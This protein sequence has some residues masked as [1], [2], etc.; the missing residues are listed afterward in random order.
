[1]DYPK[2]EPD[3]KTLGQPPAKATS[4]FRALVIVAHPDDETLWGGGTILMHPEWS[5]QVISLCRGD[6]SERRPRFFDAMQR[7]GVA[8]ASMDQLDDGP[9]QRPL[10]GRR[11][12]AALELVLANSGY[13]L[14]ITHSP[15]GE[16]TRHLRHEE[17]GRAVLQLW[18]SGVLNT[19]ELWLFA[20]SDGARTRSPTAIGEA[21]IAVP[22][23]NGVWTRKLAIIREAYG[24][25]PDSWEAVSAPKVEAFW[26]FDAPSRAL[27]WQR[28]YRARH[29]SPKG[30]P[31]LHS[32]RSIT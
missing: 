12:R 30:T 26:C 21:D 6:D 7:L 17:V 5:W 3:D 15:F 20:Y 16:Y 19:D 22:L 8:E 9:E 32:P 18:D 10:A 13:D 31:W 23:P 24:F 29:T 1:M 25:D 14:V 28:Q 27:I 4:N 2:L 11:I